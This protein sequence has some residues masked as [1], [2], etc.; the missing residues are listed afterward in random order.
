VTNQQTRPILLVDGPLEGQWHNAPRGTTSAVFSAP[1]D[2]GDPRGL[3]PLTDD[4]QIV[5]VQVRIGAGSYSVAAGFSRSRLAMGG[6]NVDLGNIEARIIRWLFT[7]E[8]AD[9]L[10]ELDV[11]A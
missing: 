10:L 6:I 7:R 2:I 8:A 11:T 5:D 9:V 4:Y 3:R 1:L